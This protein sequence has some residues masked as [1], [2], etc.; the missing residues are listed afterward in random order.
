MLKIGWSSRDFTPRRAAMLQGQVHV[1]IA[2]SALDPLALTACALEDPATGAA[3]IFV[4]FDAAYIT[5]GLRDEVRR[6]VRQACPDI[7][8]DQIILNATHTHTSLVFDNDFYRHPGGDVMT[9]DECRALMTDCAAQA[10]GEAW[11]TRQPRLVGRAFGHAV[12]GHNRYAVYAGGSGQMYG[13]T[14]R[15]DFEGLGGYEDHSL[16]M[17]FT[18]NRDGSLAGLLV[19]IPCPSQVDEGLSQYSADYWHEVRIELRAR[20]GKNLQV[21][22]ICSPAGDQSPHFLVYGREEAE[23]RQ[24]R[25][26]TERQE[27]A[28]RVA[29]AVERALVCTRPLPPERAGL[30][31]AIRRLKLTPLKITR[32]HCRWAENALAAWRKNHPEETSWYPAS[33]KRVIQAWK[34]RIVSPPFPLELHVVRIGDA[35]L[36]TNPFELFL[37]YGLRIKARSPAP[38]TILMQLT[39]RGMYLPTA[40]ALGAGG[41]GANPVVAA[42]GPEGG[43]ELVEAT[44][45]EIQKLFEDTKRGRRPIVE[46]RRRKERHG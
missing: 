17:L 5:E 35:V 26:I 44:L 15:P 46:S 19:A 13:V 8:V 3:A 39:G 6:A 40:R 9:P 23:M 21:L 41:Y 29:A 32:E 25:G 37:D 14:N 10:I 22:P 33:L 16:D 38:Q 11:R 31:H 18:W 45:A 27:I 1:R 36:A 42:V 7:P 4:A 20:L 30:R 12:V 34:R 24:R 28:L 43:G 2:R